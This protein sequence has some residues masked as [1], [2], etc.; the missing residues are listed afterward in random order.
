M[1][2]GLS[3]TVILIII[4]ALFFDFV[5]GWNDAANSVATVV[6]TKV[7]TPIKAIGLAA[8][9]NFIAFL[10]MP[11][12]V[13]LTIGKG[14]V[15]ISI[16]TP[17]LILSTLLAA[18]FWGVFMTQ[19][20]LPISMSHTLIGG[21]MGA[22]IAAGGFQ[23]LIMSGI[24]KVLLF[25]V[26]APIFGFVFSMLFS[27]VLFRAIRKLRPSTI[28]RV[29]GKLQLLS[30][31]WY[32]LGHGANDALKTA[33]I[34]SALLISVG[35]MDIN[36][37]I[38]T[39]VILSAYISIGLG[40]LIGGWKVIRTMGMKITK[41]RPVDGFSAETGGGVLLFLTSIF[42]IPVSTTHVIAGSIMGVGATKRAT[43]VRWGLARTIVG[44]WILTIPA[45]TFGGFVVYKAFV[46]LNITL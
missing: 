15:D 40:T 41:L 4:I 31:S 24:T 28:N 37:D 36:A 11:H 19:F 42:G 14:I 5:N 30:V 22:G 35:Y 3:T 43:S 44:A 27:A 26:L 10:I 38:P 16:V 39:W 9:M 7:L 34:I 25:I 6:S 13:A 20:G 21:F 18:I 33:G 8:F 12:A 2:D 23:V 32:S 46:L 17:T 1:F 45:T 29:F